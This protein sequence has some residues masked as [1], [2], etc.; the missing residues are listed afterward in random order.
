[1]HVANSN[2]II[3][4]KDYD[5]EILISKMKKN[6]RSYFS[7]CKQIRSTS[8]PPLTTPHSH[9]QK[10]AHTGPECNEPMDHMSGSDRKGSVIRVVPEGIIDRSRCAARLCPLDLPTLRK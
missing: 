3:E 7:L 2:K 10:K 8:T 1:L 5:D 9:P 6:S 4:E